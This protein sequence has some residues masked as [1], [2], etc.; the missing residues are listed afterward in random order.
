MAHQEFPAEIGPYRIIRKLGEGGMGVVVQGVHKLLGSNAAIKTI[1]HSSLDDDESIGRLKDEGRALASLRHHNIVGVYDL[2]AEQGGYFLVMEFVA[3]KPLDQYLKGRPLPLIEALGFAVE[4]GRGIAA[5]HKKGILHRDIKPQNVMISDEGD[6]KVMDFG[7]A[8]FADASTKTRT[9]MVMGTPRYMSPEQAL[10]KP[11]DGRSDQYSYGVLVYRLLCGREPFID[12]DSL[13]IVFKHVHELAPPPTRWDPTVPGDLSEIVMRSLSKDVNA[14]WPELTAMV[15]ALED[16]RRELKKQLA[17]APPPVAGAGRV[18]SAQTAETSETPVGG[19]PSA[20]GGAIPATV[21][22]PPQVTPP[23]RLLPAEIAARRMA[24]TTKPPGEIPPPRVVTTVLPATAEPSRA[25]TPALAPPQAAGSKA[26][27]FAVAGFLLVGLLAGGGWLLRGKS[28]A[29]G[30][31]G[32][33]VAAA[34]SALMPSSAPLAGG[35]PPGADAAA[36]SS[37][38]ESAA[39]NSPAASSV[40]APETPPPPAALPT[41]APVSAPTVKPA[42]AAPVKPRPAPANDGRDWLEGTWSGS[43]KQNGHLWTIK[44]SLEPK[45]GFF[46]AQYPSLGCR[47]VLVLSGRTAKFARF[48][49]NI[50]LNPEKKCAAIG[51]VLL[52]PRKDGGLNYQ[53]NQPGDSTVAASGVLRRK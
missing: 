7:L 38:A 16:Y 12:G 22:L 13:A 35:L 52:T 27:L 25:V 2:I 5:A 20:Q 33:Q 34:A 47:G 32:V 37:A 14:R 39:A 18:A 46:T 30:A 6:I 3:G 48:R 24:V 8:K 23:A 31:S 51:V 50:N 17:A 49:E 21:R 53:W 43:A 4:I 40:S 44:L 42:P 11:L 15:D 10:A 26:P 45:A 19:T 28:G 9:G 36:G 1:L 41:L 29:S